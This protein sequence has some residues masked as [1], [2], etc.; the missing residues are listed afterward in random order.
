[1]DAAH[2]L[3]V[4]GASTTGQQDADTLAA[5]GTVE[6]PPSAAQLLTD[7]FAAHCAT[8]AAAAEHK[9]PHASQG[10]GQSASSAEASLVAGVGRGWDDFRVI[11][12]EVGGV[13]CV[14]TCNH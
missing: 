3:S 4:W 8:A 7:D 1:M 13:A 5:W 12:V 10:G 14:G 6:L 9:R 11:A 2:T